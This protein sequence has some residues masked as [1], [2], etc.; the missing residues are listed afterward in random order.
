[1]Q[2]RTIN[3]PV[4]HPARALQGLARQIA[5]PHE[6]APERFPSFPALERTATM[7]FDTT[8][9]MVVPSSTVTK[10]MLARQAAWP[11]WAEQSDANMAYAVSYQSDQSNPSSTA[12]LNSIFPFH[13][14]VADWTLGNQSATL[15]N[16]G[17]TGAGGV[18]PLSYPIMAID[19][20]TGSMPWTYIPTNW[21]LHFVLSNG[22]GTVNPSAPFNATLTAELWTSPGETTTVSYT[23]AVWGTGVAASMIPNLT[24]GGVWVRPIS[25]IFELSGGANYIDVYNF[26]RCTVVAST[27]QAASLTSGGGTLGVINLNAGTA[28]GLRPLVQPNEFVNSQLPW[29]STRTTA[30]AALFTNVSQVLSKGGTVLAGRVSPQVA[31]P[32]TVSLA[33]VNGLHPAE[34]SY[35]PLETGYYTYCPPSSDLAN[36]WDYTLPTGINNTSKQS[37][38][39]RLDNDS[40]VNVA[41]FTA[42]GSDCTLAVT[43]DWHVEFRTSSS[44]FMIG[45]SAMTL[46]SLHQAQLALANVGFF[47]E[48]PDHKRILE[49]VTAAVKRYGPHIAE[50]IHPMLG[51]AARMGVLMMSRANKP[52]PHPS[53]GLAIAGNTDKK[54][55]GKPKY[56][57]PPRP[58]N[59]RPNRGRRRF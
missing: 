14:G 45:M 11:L 44:L 29:F 47:F 37:P 24:G 7:A 12:Q 39:Y 32:F 38:I 26:L 21:Y 15:G 17:V 58:G 13:G 55:Q 43:A 57:G 50:A 10:V 46:E 40:M 1:M 8:Q 28:K 16:I 22:I 54:K 53:T 31:N 18:F 36:F 34:K 51:K 20:G 3:L 9:S 23:A 35:L 2:Q 19:Q 30:S 27:G 49:K 5:L 6:Y 33:Y 52:V 41:F 42:P 56:S 25:V 59:K 48:N 4:S